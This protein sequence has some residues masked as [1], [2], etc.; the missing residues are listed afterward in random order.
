M[1]AYEMLTKLDTGVEIDFEGVK[2]RKVGDWQ[3]LKPGDTYIAERNTGPK[4]LTVREV[5][6]ASAC[7]YAKEPAYAFDLGEVRKIEIIL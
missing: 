4:L 2:I 7:I 5:D 6:L 3:D 1:R